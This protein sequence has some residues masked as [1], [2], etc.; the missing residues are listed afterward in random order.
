M[1][2]DGHGARLVVASGDRNGNNSNL[3]GQ[4]VV[5]E[6]KTRK[7]TEMK[8]CDHAS[9]LARF[10]PD[11]HVVVSGGIDGVGRVHD[12]ATGRLIATLVGHAQP[13]TALDFSPDGTRLVT[14]SGDRTARIWNP[15]SW[16]GSRDGES[17]ASWSSEVTL[18]GHKA[19]LLWAEF[20]PDGTLVLTCGYDRTARIWDAQTGEC[21]VTQVGHE[22]TVNKARFGAGIPAGDRRERSD[23]SGLD[24][25]ECRGG[26]PG[27]RQAQRDDARRL[28]PR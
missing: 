28:W 11:G 3:P 20:S 22:G 26:P 8:K 14:A 6:L 4:V 19:W 13:I 7:K 25:R 18:V 15:R 9:T 21:L 24:D 10:S 23:G 2:F 1:A 16:S 5:F 12:V 27:A 17:T